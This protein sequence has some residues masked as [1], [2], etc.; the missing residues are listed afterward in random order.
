MKFVAIF[1]LLLILFMGCEV[2]FGFPVKHG[3]QSE[4]QLCKACGTERHASGYWVGS[5]AF[6]VFHGSDTEK[7]TPVARFLAARGGRC[8]AHAWRPYYAQNWYTGILMIMRSVARKPCAGKVLEQEQVLNGI[9]PDLA[10]EVIRA[11]LG[12]PAYD[13]AAAGVPPWFREAAWPPK[14]AAE[15]QAW[16]AR[17]K[18][19]VR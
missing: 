5:P 15:A 14:D 8:A 16:W 2:L 9:D 12:N 18:G 10:M 1:G 13:D 11:R 17:Q 7:A 4:I 3:D 19:G 6:R